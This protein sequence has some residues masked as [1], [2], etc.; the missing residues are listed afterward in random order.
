MYLKKVICLFLFAAATLSNVV[1]LDQCQRVDWGKIQADGGGPTPTPVPWPAALDS[2]RII[3]DGGGPT[4]T[5][6]PWASES[7]DTEFLGA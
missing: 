5:P 3:A 2:P 1:A 6:V 4:P 7:A